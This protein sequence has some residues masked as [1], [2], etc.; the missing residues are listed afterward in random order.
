MPLQYLVDNDID[1]KFK[2]EGGESWNDVHLRVRQLIQLLLSRCNN[3]PCDELSELSSIMPEFPTHK[4]SVN[5]L[6][7]THQGFIREFFLALRK[8][9]AAAGTGYYAPNASLFQIKFHRD[10]VNDFRT[11]FLV[12]NSKETLHFPFSGVVC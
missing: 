10:D 9:T 6:L 2:F 1:R 3:E 5:V 12:M 11:E 7:I 4:Q 8:H